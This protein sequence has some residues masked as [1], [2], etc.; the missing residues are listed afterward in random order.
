[1][2]IEQCKDNPCICI[3]KC[4][5]CGKEFTG[6]YHVYR[7]RKYHI[8]NRC[9]IEKNNIITKWEKQNEKN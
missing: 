9:I 8:C 7:M 5:E 2:F 4:D 3:L 1:M 6:N